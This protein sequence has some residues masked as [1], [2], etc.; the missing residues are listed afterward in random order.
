[1]K[2]T[3]EVSE[4]IKGLQHPLKPE[5]EAVRQ[6]IL[7]ANDRIRE[8]IKWNAPSFYVEEH[9]A[10]FNLRARDFVQVILH[11]GAKV[12]S[13]KAELFEIED[14]SGLLEW[15]AKDRGTIKFHGL[16]DVASKRAAFEGIINRWIEAMQEKQG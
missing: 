4:F 13:A 14:P 8:E 16:S 9:F 10:T 15:L 7:G 2:K 11:R 6:I 3:E 12:Q 1:M 5:I